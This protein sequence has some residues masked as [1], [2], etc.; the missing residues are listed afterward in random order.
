MIAAEII[1]IVLNFFST[2][3]SVVKIFANIA[4]LNP[5]KTLKIIFFKKI[6]ITN[7]IRVMRQ[8]TKAL[9]KPSNLK[10]STKEF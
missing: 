1:L 4:D 7:W 5:I 8:R 6:T 2:V 9:L 3:I 10:N